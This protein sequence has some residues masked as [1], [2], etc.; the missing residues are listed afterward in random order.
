MKRIGLVCLLILWVGLPAGC[1]HADAPEN[2]RPLAVQMIY[3]STACGKMVDTLKD[4]PQAR[5]IADRTDLE[6]LFNRRDR[7]R[8]GAR[9]PKWVESFNFADS[10]ILFVRMGQKPTGG[11][12]LEYIP[13]SAYISNQTA[14]VGLQW[15]AP[16][17]D[18]MVTQV[19]TQPCIM[20]KMP[21]ADF[22]RIHI[23][24]G[25]G[26]LKTAVYRDRSD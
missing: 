7:R 21:K 20:L 25:H 24:D 12:H 6:V 22:S 19:I 4:K 26:E 3:K 1:T 9:P 11:Y 14:E 23:R 15:V 13:G 16:A 2:R 8:I 10:G 18:Q 17:P 5:W